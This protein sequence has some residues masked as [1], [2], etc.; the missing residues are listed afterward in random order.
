MI[1]YKLVTDDFKTRPGRDNETVWRIGES[2]TATG[3][4]GLCTNG[5]IHSYE[6]PLH[7]VFLAPL[8]VDENHTRLIEIECSDLVADDGLKGGSKRAMMSR[9]LPLPEIMPEQRIEVA[10]RTVLAIPNR[11]IIAG[12]D[13]W[14][15]RWL[16]GERDNQAARAA[17]TAARTAEYAARTAEYAAKAAD[18]AEYA[19]RTADAAKA[20][21]YAAR[22]ADAAEYAAE[23]A[24]R[25]AEYAAE[26]AAEYAAR[27]AEYAAKAAAY[28][29][30]KAAADAVL[31]Q[32]RATF[33]KI[34]QEVC[35]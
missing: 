11:P 22:T 9:E 20:A 4:G 12:W 8:H 27:T 1:R 15:T 24:A 18:A 10:I 28:A 29:E 30:A 25:T 16:S 17:R 23:Y 31:H 33:S 6:S 13:D 34:L 7:A 26:C 2:V 14:A 5:V 21:E 19:A 3:R 32:F 35:A